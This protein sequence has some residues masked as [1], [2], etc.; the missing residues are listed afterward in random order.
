[1]AVVEEL[2]R[3]EANGAVSFG[4]YQL[5]TKS[6]KED[7]ELAGDLYKV[8]TFYEITKLEKNGMFVYE[9]VPG[10]AVTDF[11][12]R[13]DGLRFTVWGDKDAEITVQLQESAQY[14]IDFDGEQ[15][16]MMETNRS[17]KL[18]LGVSLDEGRPVRVE[19]IRR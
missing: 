15:H 17:G 18:S 4:N 5:Q 11:E 19:I 8:K 13:E 1:M 14:V 3:G 9:S 2:V 12:A 16:G 10:T 6:K 7:V